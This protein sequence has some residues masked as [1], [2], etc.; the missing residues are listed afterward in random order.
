MLDVV[1]QLLPP[2]YSPISQAESDLGVGP[3]GWVMDINFVVRGT[4]SLAVVYGLYRLWPTTRPLPR[5]SLALVG[6]WGVGAFILAFNPADVSG[7][8]TVHGT[9]HGITA[10]LVFLFVAVGVV[11]ISEA[12]PRESPWAAV[13]PY[14]RTLAVLTAIALVVLAIGS[15]VHRVEVHYFGLLERIFIGFA[16]LWMLTVSVLLLR[17]EPKVEAAAQ[18]ASV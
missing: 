7:V 10:I 17:A 9:I 3:Y 5:Y 4:L 18:T 13:R 8:T 6:A 16:L 14:A 15:V 2:H 12:M 1:A 11:G